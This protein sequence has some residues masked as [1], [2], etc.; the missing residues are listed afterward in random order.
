MVARY[1]H[2]YQQGIER[3]WNRKDRFDYYLPSFANLGEQAVLNKEIYAQ[4]TAVDN[5]VFGYQE[6]WADYR[7]KPNRVTGE[8]RSTHTTSLDVWHLG[9]EY[10]TL[11][12]LSDAWIS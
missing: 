1:E 10:S 8:M 5:Q 3:F 7:Y 6:A 9:D 11:P 4:G 2:T 12:R